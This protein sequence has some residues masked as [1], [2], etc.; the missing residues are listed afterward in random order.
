MSGRPDLF[1]DAGMLP[2]PHG[3][4]EAALRAISQTLQEH[5]QSFRGCTVEFDGDQF[6]VRFTFAHHASIESPLDQRAGH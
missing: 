4:A 3:T 2:D 5:P 1:Q 6:G